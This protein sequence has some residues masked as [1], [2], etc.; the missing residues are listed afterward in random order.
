[1]TTIADTS[2][3]RGTK[4]PLLLFFYS[5][6][7]GPS[8][9]LDGLVSCLYVRER[10]RLRL[11][12]VDVSERGDVAERLN[13]T[14]VPA[15]VLVKGKQVVAQLEGKVTGQQIRDTVLPHLAPERRAA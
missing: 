1:M 3:E 6:T 11:A 4:R 12:K 9:R 15:L 8:R 2:T 7:S 5:P 13:I 10:A 14:T